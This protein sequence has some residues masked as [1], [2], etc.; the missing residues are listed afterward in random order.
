MTMN[1]KTF[2]TLILLKDS[3]EATESDRLALEGHLNTCNTCKDMA[4]DLASLRQLF[5]DQQDMTHGP[6]PTVLESIHVTADEKVTGIHRAIHPLWKVALAAA[7]CF[8]VFL[9][10]P[11][12]R[13]RLRFC[14][15]L[16][17]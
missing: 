1:C 2:E 14:L 4:S 3:G 15:C 7:A 8:F 5:Q 6:S 9:T 13:L 17:W 11:S 10:L 12:T 16:T